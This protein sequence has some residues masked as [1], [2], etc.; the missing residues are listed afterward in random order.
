M[1]VGYKDGCCSVKTS[2][3]IPSNQVTPDKATLISTLSE[4]RWEAETEI[5]GQASL[6]CEAAESGSQ[7]SSAAPWQAHNRSHTSVQT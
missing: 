3:Q 2:V 1:W 5:Q 7:V 4:V 6:L